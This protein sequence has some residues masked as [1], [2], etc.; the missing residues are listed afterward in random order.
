MEET[1]FQL[2]VPSWRDH[3]NRVRDYQ[4]GRTGPSGDWVYYYP[5][6]RQNVSLQ[7]ALNRVSSTGSQPLELSDGWDHE[8]D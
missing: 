5:F 7:V 3:S 8:E 1:N 2:V 4:V 6:E